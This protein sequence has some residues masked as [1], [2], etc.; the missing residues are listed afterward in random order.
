MPTIACPQ[1]GAVNETALLDRRCPSCGATLP[2][3]LAGPPAPAGETPPRSEHV[4]EFDLVPRYPEP[5]LSLEPISPEAKIRRSQ[6]GETLAVL[7]LLL[8]LVAQG[9]ALA[10]HFDS[11][12]EMA[13]SWGTVAVT[14]LLLAADAALLGPVDLQRSRRA[15]PA[16]LFFGMIFLWIVCYPVVFFRRRHFG[17]P[18]LGPLAI[19]VAVFF[20]AV[21]FVHQFRRFGVVNGGPPTCTSREVTTMVDDMIRKSAIGP[22]VLSISGHREISHDL[23]GQSRKGQCLVET[24]TET[25]TVTYTV[26]LLNRTNGT[27]QVEIEPIIPVDPPSCTNPEVIALLEELIRDGRNGHQLKKVEDHEEVRYD[28]ENK[29]RHGRC[30]VTMQD[31]MGHVGYKVYWANPK[32]GQFQVQIEPEAHIRPGD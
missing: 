28:R 25:I 18:N 6:H 30:R 5:P 32:T 27:F 13:L 2:D 9:V 20:V 29:T 14:A 4:A 7:A 19:L 11:G 24:Q 16:A 17:R 12:I 3:E 10:G 8:P 23:V 1:C 15:S 26:K 21:P 22:S 31:W